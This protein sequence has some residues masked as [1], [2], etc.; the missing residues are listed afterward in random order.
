MRRVAVRGRAGF[1][2]LTV[3]NAD[4]LSLFLRTTTQLQEF[5]NPVFDRLRLS[6]SCFD[7]E[8]ALFHALS[9]P[10]PGVAIIETERAPVELSRVAGFLPVIVVS[11]AKEPS[12]GFV[13]A[14]RGAFEVIDSPVNHRLLEAYIAKAVQEA[15]D[16]WEKY[17]V[18]NETQQRLENLS[19][20][21]TQVC[22]LLLEG[23][24]TREV[25]AEL[26]IST[27]TVEKHRLKV[28]D[29]MGVNSVAKLIRLVELN[30]R[31]APVKPR[32]TTIQ[33]T[34]R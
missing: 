6:L 29:K 31:P 18:K 16:Y 34:S 20:R 13:A 15:G 23:R 19:A 11:T 27:S 2:L 5:L 7:S 21:E 24:E 8:A 22:G 26:E 30:K 4:S 9:N 25:A 14:K 1:G 33:S 12:V 3:Y 10:Q 32:D 17:S 28:F